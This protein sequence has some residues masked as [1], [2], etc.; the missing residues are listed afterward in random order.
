M[1]WR[2]ISEADLSEC[3]EIQPECLG[4]Q[5][6]GRSAALR[7]WES[8]LDNP[9]FLANVIESERSLSGHKVVACGMGVFVS[10]TFADRELADPRPG[11]N[12]RIIAG[13]VSGESIVLSRA[14]I[15]VGNA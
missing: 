9:A 8:F 7:V 12:S 3:L 10:K 13:V 1:Y 2:P 15:G 14:E 11:L 5:I 6:V 4:A